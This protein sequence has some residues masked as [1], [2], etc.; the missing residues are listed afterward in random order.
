MSQMIDIAATMNLIARGLKLEIE[1]LSQLKL[2]VILHWNLNHFVVLEKVDG[3][4]FT[5]FDPGV[6]RTRVTDKDMNKFFSGIAI[7]LSPA[8]KFKKRAEKSP[9]PLREWIKITPSLYGSLSQILILS[10]VL[11]AY[12][13][14]SPFFLQ[15]S[16]DQGVQ[17]GDAGIIVTLAIGFAFLGLFNVGAD[18]MRGFVTQ[19][20]SALLSWDMSLR[21]FQHLMRL[22]LAWFQRRRLAD[23]LSR[24]DSINPIRDLIS[25]ALISTLVDG[26]LGLTTLVM[27]LIFAPVLAGLVVVFVGLSIGLRLIVLP[28]TMRLGSEM[29]NSQIAESGRRIEAVRAIQTIK[30]MNGEQPQMA[31]WA[32]QYGLLL[33]RKVAKARFDLSVNAIDQSA[34]LVLTTLVVLI[35]ARAIIN[36]HMTVGLLYAFL[37]Y[38]TQFTTAAHNIAA[39]ITQ[40]RMTDLFSFRLADIVLTPPE[41]GLDRIDEVGS[42]FAGSIVLDSV[43]Y[44][45]SSY[46]PFILR[47]VS[48]TIAAGESVAI[49]GPSGCGKSTLLKLLCGL[50]QPTSGEIRLDG[51]NLAAWGTKAIRDRFGVVM[52]DDELL[53]GTVAENVS[54][55]DDQID[56]N[57]VWEALRGA[58]IAEEIQGLPLKLQT[59][60]GEMGSNISGGQKQRLLLARALYKRPNVLLL[61]EATS[62]VDVATEREINEYLRTQNITR[63]SIAHRIETIRSAE[64]VFDI[65]GV[66]IMPN[67]QGTDRDRANQNAET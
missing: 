42:T 22:P 8:A 58:A 2:P 26:V 18:L 3:K 27:M 54:F 36:N 49:V 53:S 23:T 66:Q 60:I 67:L 65:R 33:K 21:L 59:I 17:R 62:H 55:F 29:L 39:Q 4:R 40:W 19:Q 16:I 13:V 28:T 1:E 37:A 10:F 5:I 50:Y 43:S 24:F 31:K 47:N 6:G 11:Q 25:G 15:L 9:L 56:A 14:A 64:R 63:I 12:A 46:E 51:R 30:V 32:N 48:L 45:Y 44:R 38:K 20:V 35:G 52:Q 7:E 34:E 57:R 41:P 61:D